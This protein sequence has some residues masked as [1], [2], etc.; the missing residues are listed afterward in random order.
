VIVSPQKAHSAQAP[1]VVNAEKKIDKF[2]PRFL[3]LYLS[4][5]KFSETTVEKTVEKI[6][7]AIRENPKVTHKQL[8]EIT[9][10]TKGG[11]EWNIDKLKRKGII[12]HVGPNKG[13]R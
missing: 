13:G 6:I 3:A 4:A 7:A 2:K 8:M 5:G 1:R 9:G 12:R 10:L 11:V